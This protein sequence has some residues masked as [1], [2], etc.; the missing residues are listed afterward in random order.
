MAATDM[1]AAERDAFLSDVRVGILAVERPGKG[2]L[3]LPVWYQYADG[4]ILVTMADDSAKA[5]LLRRAGRATFTVQD[6][7][8]PYRYASVEGPVAL[9][10]EPHDVTDLAIRYLGPD[11]GRQYAAANPPNEHTAVVRLTPERWLTCDYGK[12]GLT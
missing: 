1:T 3:A 8:P 9:T 7:R 2:P 11:L 10:T 4:A 12:T 5:R 6:E